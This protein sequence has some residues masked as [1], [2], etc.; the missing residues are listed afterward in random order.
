MKKTI[1]VLLVAATLAAATLAAEPGFAWEASLEVGVQ[2]ARNKLSFGQRPDATDGIDGL[3]DVPALLSG[4]IKACFL[5]EGDKYWR[6][7]KAEGAKQWVLVIE[8]ELEGEV[9][10]IGW[11]P[12][13]L[14]EQADIV[15]MDDTARMAFDMKTGSSYSYKNDSPRQFRIEVRR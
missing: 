8:S 14:P 2:N 5:L 15:L 13:E 4:D 10:S 7:V 3:Y 1:W 12:G 6:D 11:K 9:I